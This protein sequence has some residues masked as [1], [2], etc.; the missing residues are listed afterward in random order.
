MRDSFW[1]PVAMMMWGL[2]L[3]VATIPIMFTPLGWVLLIGGN[4][5]GLAVAVLV[6]NLATP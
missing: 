4:V 2:V 6:D 5:L 3:V 1:F